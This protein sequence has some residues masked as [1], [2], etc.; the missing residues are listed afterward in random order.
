MIGADV[1]FYTTVNCMSHT[2]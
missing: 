1:I 2:L